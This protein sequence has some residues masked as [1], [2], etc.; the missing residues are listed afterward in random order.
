MAETPNLS[1]LKDLAEV[2]ETPP[3]VVREQKIDAQG[4]AYA[5]GRRKVAV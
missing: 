3:A 4:R 1:D 2:A 5:T